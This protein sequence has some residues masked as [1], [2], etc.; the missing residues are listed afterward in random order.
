MV[1][2]IAPRRRG[3]L[4][5]AWVLAKGEM[6]A[7]LRGRSLLFGTAVGIVLVAAYL[8]IQ[9]LVVN[10]TDTETVGLTGQATV[11]TKT[12]QTATGQLGLTV[13]VTNVTDQDTGLAQ[14]HSGSLT[15]L[16]AGPP[17]ALQVTVK[18]QLDPRL[19][20]ALTGLVQAQAL[21]AQL[22]EAGL[23][24][25]DVQAA[26]G[27]AQLAVTQL[28]PTDPLRAQRL[29]LAIA[30]AVLLYFALMLLGNLLA[31]GVV[32]DRV[33]RITEVLLSAAR[34][35]H[36]LLGKVFGLGVL[37]FVQLAVVGL[38]GLAIA[39]GTGVL[40][41]TGLGFGTLGAGLLWYLLGFAFYA[42][43]FAG[44]GALVVRLEELQAVLTPIVLTA[45]VGFV[46]GIDLLVQAPDGAAT[47]VVSLLPPFAPFLMP[48]RIALGVAEGWQ[49]WLAVLLML[50]AIVVV[51]GYCGRTYAAAIRTIGARVK[52]KDALL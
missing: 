12:L 31:R 33:N 32:T 43:L 25:S 17:G 51:A 15:A 49:I 26:V 47:A 7:R 13:H 18:D 41:A 46:V 34:P 2:E 36:L 1:T 50:A 4:R 38:A 30:A 14:V 28:Q 8:L 11:L 10:R 3:P 42:T 16:V 20:A 40:T 22:A 29:G 44:I 39:A 19:R 9:G 24:P 5:A 45:S 48:G 52:L 35:G 37:G 21:D 6:R 27:K 23:K